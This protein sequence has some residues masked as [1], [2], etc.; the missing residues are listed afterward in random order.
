M[1][2]TMSDR[3]LSAGGPLLAVVVPTRDERENIVPL[4][5]RLRATLGDIDW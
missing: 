2:S 5:E 1:E 4:Y 3:G